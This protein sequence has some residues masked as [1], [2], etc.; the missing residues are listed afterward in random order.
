MNFRS[1]GLVLKHFS[2]GK[3]AKERAKISPIDTVNQNDNF[4]E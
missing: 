4:N 2:C 1:M 3:F